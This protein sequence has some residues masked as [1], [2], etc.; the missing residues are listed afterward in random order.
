MHS[1]TSGRNLDLLQA[2]CILVASDL[3]LFSASPVSLQ[4][5]GNMFYLFSRTSDIKIMEYATFC[6]DTVKVEDRRKSMATD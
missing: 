4:N 6:Y 1:E 5:I 2:K 3:S